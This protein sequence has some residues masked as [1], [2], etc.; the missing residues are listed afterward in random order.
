MGFHSEVREMIETIAEFYDHRVSCTN[1]GIVVGGGGIHLVFNDEGEITYCIF[2]GTDVN[3][4]ADYERWVDLVRKNDAGTPLA[5]HAA[6]H[7]SKR[8]LAPIN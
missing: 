8:T 7:V 4:I 6:F 5:N 1:L 2:E 3:Q